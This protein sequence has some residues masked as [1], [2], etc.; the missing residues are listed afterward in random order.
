MSGFAVVSGALVLTAGACVTWPLWRA[1]V[2][3][4]QPA[5]GRVWAAGLT[6][7]LAAFT[8]A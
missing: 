1:R 7:A 8:A 3:D 5:G 2:A 4:P 6:V